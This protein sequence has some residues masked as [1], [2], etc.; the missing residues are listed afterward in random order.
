M[1][2]VGPLSARYRCESCGRSRM[3]DNYDQLKVNDG[4]YFTHW[5][6]RLLAAFGVTVDTE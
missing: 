2:E 6:S 3:N 1:S 5:R 4:P